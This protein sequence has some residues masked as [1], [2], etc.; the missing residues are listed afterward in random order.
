MINLTLKVICLTF[1]MF[2]FASEQVSFTDSVKIVRDLDGSMEIFFVKRAGVFTGP[3]DGAALEK[4]IMSQKSGAAVQVSV[5]E[6]TSKI[7][8]VTSADQ[9]QKSTQPASDKTK[10]NNGK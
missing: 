1:G 7:L 10:K 9:E 3:D 5:D 8:R 4:L 6:K 2:S